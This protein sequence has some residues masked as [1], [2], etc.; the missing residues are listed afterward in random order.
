[1][2]KRTGPYEA[3]QTSK[4]TPPYVYG[5]SGPGYG[6]GYNAWL[7]YPQNTFDN[8]E[9]AQKAARLMNLAFHQGE[10]KR[11]REIKALLE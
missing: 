10:A 9:D 8:W 7:G 2:I 6:L 1:V 3:C 11:A 5:V 4:D